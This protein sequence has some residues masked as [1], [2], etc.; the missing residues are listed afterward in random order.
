MATKEPELIRHREKYLETIL[1]WAYQDIDFLLKE[2]FDTNATDCEMDG[3]K[4]T[5]K[6]IRK[7]LAD[8]EKLQAYIGETA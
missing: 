1:L 5:L 4:R 6:E 3:V 7:A 2:E 8:Y